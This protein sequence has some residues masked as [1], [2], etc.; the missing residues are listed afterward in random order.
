[1]AT[2]SEYDDTRSL[3]LRALNLIL[4]SASSHRN[5]PLGF[6]RA[7]PSVL[8][9]ALKHLDDPTTISLVAHV[10]AHS[11]ASLQR[12]LESALDVSAFGR[13]LLDALKQPTATEGLLHHT[14]TCLS[15]STF[16]MWEKRDG[17]PGLLGFYVALLRSTNLRLRVTALR[18]VTTQFQFWDMHP[19][20]PEQNRGTVA[21]VSGS[22]KC[23]RGCISSA[24]IARNVKFEDL[25][26]KLLQIADRYGKNKTH[27]VALQRARAAYAGIFLQYSVENDLLDIARALSRLIYQYRF[28]LPERLAPATGAITTCRDCATQAPWQNLICKCVKALRDQPA[29]SAEDSVAADI[30][31]WKIYSEWHAASCLSEFCKEALERNPT[32]PLLYY[33][34]NRAAPGEMYTEDFLRRAKKGLMCPNIPDWLRFELLWQAAS[35]GLQCGVKKA[36]DREG[37]ADAHLFLSTARA[38]AK[39]L[40]DEM[41]PDAPRRCSALVLYVWTH[42]AL[43]GPSCDFEDPSIQVSL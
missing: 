16:K 26:P 35:A 29:L 15:S 10:I 9:P 13:L 4:L 1:M 3:A 18:M 19:T 33:L 23:K 38:D 8:K 6:L 24:N 25:P 7:A 20:E 27:L 41:P 21:V 22:P 42:L 32:C 40:I 11:P 30:L 28:A 37:M 2:L 34:P 31:D 5:L 39:R 14:L 43:E 12:D 17:I 36:G